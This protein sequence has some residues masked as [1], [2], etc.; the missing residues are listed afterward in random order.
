MTAKE[1]AVKL[2]NK[3]IIPTSERNF[4]APRLSELEY[5]GKV[6]VITK[7]KCQYTGKVVSVYEKVKGAE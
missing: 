2:C 5:Q 1:L 7:E 4:T 6:K 3:G